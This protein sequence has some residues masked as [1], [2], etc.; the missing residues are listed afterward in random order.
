MTNKN[1]N[2]TS[3]EV[4]AEPSFFAKN[5]K[6]LSIGVGAV[7]ILCL[8]FVGYKKLVAEPRAQEAQEAIVAAQDFIKQ[9]Q[10]DKALASANTVISEY[11]STESG[12]LAQLYAGIA[13]YNQA[14]YQ[15]AVDA[16]SKY[17]ET[18]SDVTDAEVLQALG[19]CYACLKQYDK[20]VDKLTAA[21]DKAK[22]ATL[23]PSY[24]IQAGEIYELAL[25]NKDKARECYQKAKDQYK[26]SYMVSSGEVDKYLERVK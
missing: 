22:N 26:T 10:Y 18:G 6:K 2:K 21:A 11:G 24:L 16:L 7:A 1:V 8:G 17:E 23:S 20:A 14:K 19:N 9:G 4:V 12:N 13:L 5:W 15:E 3:E 25:N